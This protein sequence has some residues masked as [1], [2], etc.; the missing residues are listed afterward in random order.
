MLPWKDGK[1]I[2]RR[3]EEMKGSKFKCIECVKAFAIELQ[4]M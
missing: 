2:R 4:I 3:P 1:E